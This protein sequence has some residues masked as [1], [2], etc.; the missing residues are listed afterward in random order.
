MQ[1]AKAKQLQTKVI[2]QRLGKDNPGGRTGLPGTRTQAE[3]KTAIIFKQLASDILN[4]SIYRNNDYKKNTS[5]NILNAIKKYYKVLPLET[6]IEKHDVPDHIFSKIIL[7]LD[8][9]IKSESGSFSGIEFNDRK[10]LIYR[11]DEY[12]NISDHFEYIPLFYFEGIKRR[13]KKLY[14]LILDMVC[15]ASEKAGIFLPTQ[16]GSE[17]ESVIEMFQED[18]E[19]HLESDEEGH[20]GLKTMINE[21]SLVH[22]HINSIVNRRVKLKFFKMDVEKYRSRDIIDK[23][24]LKWLRIGIEMIETGSKLYDFVWHPSSLSER[25]EDYPVTPMSYNRFVW[26]DNDDIWQYSMDV[27]DETYGNYGASPFFF[28]YALKSKG[29]MRKEKPQFP[30]LLRKFLSEGYQVAFKIYRKYG[31]KLDR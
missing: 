12:K 7:R 4:R 27:M 19:H 20:E 29:T 17:E 21:Y 26:K 30:Y 5:G 2:S 22:N 18:Y 25:Y 11:L 24:V 31:S 23:E 3:G 8:E 1:K 14:S 6:E 15:L 10:G 16:S 13:K 9:K 28:R